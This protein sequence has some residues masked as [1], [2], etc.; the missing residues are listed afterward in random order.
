VKHKSLET[1]V[2][3]SRLFAA[4]DAILGGI[5]S[6][7]GFNAR[8]SMHV[9]PIRSG[10]SLP[11]SVFTSNELMEAMAMLIR[12]DLLPA[13][14]PARIPVARDPND[15]VRKQTPLGHSPQEFAS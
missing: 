12:M 4:A 8:V 15:G 1:V 14:E 6:P 10:R 7:S 11:E 2:S 5:H 3:P 13:H 9:G